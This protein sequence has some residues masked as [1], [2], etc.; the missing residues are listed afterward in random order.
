MVEELKQIPLLILAGGKATRLKGLSADTPKY[1]MP[2]DDKTTFADFHLKWAKEQGFTKVI[3]SLG[4]LAEKIQA[5]VQDGSRYGLNVSYIL[6]GDS[7][8]GT[9]GALTQALAHNFETL[10]VTYGDTILELNSRH[11]VQL[12]HKSGLQA[13]M[14]VFENKVADHRPNCDFKNSLVT[15]DKINP[16]KDWRYIDYGFLLLK[17]QVI[18]SF[19]QKIPLDLAEPMSAL[20]RQNQVVGFE[21]KERFWEIGTPESLA[22][23]RQQFGFHAT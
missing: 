22:E 1:L 3:L 16:A 17:R 5:H 21:A 11:L 15:Y 6:D 14:T 2:L 4:H 20:S 12:L 13:L 8:R 23:F 10:A 18:E 19:A 9:G 7:P